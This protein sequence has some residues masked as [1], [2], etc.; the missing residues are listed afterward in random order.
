MTGNELRF[1]VDGGK[2]HVQAMQQYEN[3]GCCAAELLI[4]LVENAP[5]DFEG[6]AGAIFY[7]DKPPPDAA[8]ESGRVNFC[9][10]LHRGQG[11][12]HLPFPCPM[13]LRWP[14]IG[15][16]DAEEMM[17]GL[18]ADTREWESEKLFWIGTDQHPSRRALDVL[19][20]RHPKGL[21]VELME[22]DRSTPQ[23][24]ASKTRQVSV[25]D[26]RLSKYL[27]D[28][29]GRGYSARLKWLLA[30]GRPVFVVD[31]P[32]VE[33][34]HEELEPWVH[35]V[36]VAA[37]LSDLLE[38]LARLEADAGLY[39]SISKNAREFAAE[40]LTVEAM[41]TRTLKGLSD[42]IRAVKRIVS[43]GNI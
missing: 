5:E 39:E 36:P 38:H 7:G 16:P 41:L 2:V 8:L 3:R 29:P 13:S 9:T 4:D 14:E 26:H 19:G 18:L 22:W 34:W 33:H 17:R 20:R 25:P 37:D 30:T 21:D 40:H 43:D 15:V 11:R 27:A 6:M 32:V 23:A 35:H 28:C 31:R 12:R 1:L 24:L 10:T 42:E